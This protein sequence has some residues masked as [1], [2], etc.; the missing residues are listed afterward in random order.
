MKS[1]LSGVFVSAPI[2]GLL[3]FLWMSNYHVAQ[4]QQE[5]SE[6]ALR[7]QEQQFDRDFDRT[8]RAITGTL[9][10]ADMVDAEKEKEA[11]QKEIAALRKRLAELDAQATADIQQS[12]E[13]AAAARESLLSVPPPGSP[14]DPGM[15]EIPKM[16]DLK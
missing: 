4:V 9:S 13:D 1:F 3:V 7:L 11:R 14:G 10:K 16:E 12:K 2:T 15:P 6:T 5:R 8:S